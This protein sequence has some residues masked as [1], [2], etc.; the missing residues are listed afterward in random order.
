MKT[1][2]I[3]PFLERDVEVFLKDKKSYAGFLSNTVSSLDSPSGEAEIDLQSGSFEIGVKISE[4]E[5]I[6]ALKQRAI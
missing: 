4:I 1:K 2:E 3:I 6:R 5:N